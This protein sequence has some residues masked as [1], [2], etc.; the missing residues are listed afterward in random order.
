MSVHDWIFQITKYF[1]SVIKYFE[2]MSKN[3]KKNKKNRKKE[4]THCR[5]KTTS[6]YVSGDMYGVFMARSII[7]I[8]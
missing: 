8:I 4:K 3:K 6:L 2:S 7:F 5:L 1:E